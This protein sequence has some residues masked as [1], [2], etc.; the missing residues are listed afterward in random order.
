ME[1][2]NEKN[3]KFGIAPSTI[4]L[5]GFLYGAALIF[6]YFESSFF[7]TYLD[8][9]LELQYWTISLMVSLSAMMG[10]VFM[11][12]WGIKSDNTRTRFGRRRPFLLF[13]IIAGSAMIIYSFSTNYFMCLILDVAIIG[14]C[15][16]AY[17]SGQRALIPDIV[18][19]EYRGRVN[20]IVSVIS[21]LGLIIA[22]AMSLFAY[23]LFSEPRGRGY[24]ITQQGHLFL[25]SIGGG[26]MILGGISGFLFIR[27]KDVNQL[28]PSKAFI[29]ELKDTFNLQEL[30]EQKEFFKLIIAITIFKSG[31][32][33]IMPFLFNFLFSLGLE[34]VQLIILIGIAAPILFIVI[35]LLGIISDRLGRKVFL[36]PGVLIASL[37]FLIL[38]IASQNPQENLIILIITILLVFIG[39]IALLVPLDTWSQDLL[40]EGKKAQFNGIL[41]I[42]NTISQMIGA[43]VGGIV[44]TI[45]GLAWIFSFVPIFLIGSIPFF[46]WVKETLP[47]GLREELA[48]F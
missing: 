43:I 25:L 7:N 16:N 21:S 48:I 6:G 23:E 19:I 15:S 36:I 5:I 11:V 45:Y 26:V 33:I 46:L 10:L 38:P 1:E 13:G 14:V 29:E 12:I 17:Y 39:A 35:L 40:P 42:I 41:N 47:D 30:K 3:Y 24:I 32:G 22:I 34:T 20:S 8:H 31:L 44:A 4:L 2:K 9:V 28:P 27:E 18:D 37:G